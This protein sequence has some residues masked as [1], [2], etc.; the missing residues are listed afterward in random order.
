[1]NRCE[2]YVVDRRY[3]KPGQCAMRRDVRSV[4]MHDV[5]IKACS[6]HR[7]LITGGRKLSI[8]KVRP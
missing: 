3:S 5:E 6:S 1:M 4:V 8:V 7:H 2:V